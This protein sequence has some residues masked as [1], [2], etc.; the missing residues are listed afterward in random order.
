MHREMNDEV[1]DEMTLSILA[2]IG[3]GVV[4]TDLQGK[5]IYLNHAAADIVGCVA[6]QAIGRKFNDIIIIYHAVNREKMS[7]P[8]DYVL[9]HHKATGLENN[10][11]LISSDGKLKYI[12]A[13]CT[14]LISKGGIL[15]GAVVV[16]RDITKIKIYEINLQKEEQNLKKLFDD[17]PARVLVVDKNRRVVKVND[18]IIKNTGLMSE[19]IIGNGIGVSLQC[20]GSFESEL[21]CGYSKR[22]SQCKLRTAVDTLI[23]SGKDTKNTEIN[24][25]LLRQGVQENVWFN[26]NVTL[27]RGQEDQNFIVTLFDISI[28]KMKEIQARE[29]VDYCNNILNQIPVV[30]WMTDEKYI[31]SYV[32][33]PLS[34]LT[35]MNF[36]HAPLRRWFRLAHP[37]DSKEFRKAVCQALKRKTLFIKETRFLDARNEYRWFTVIG[38]PFFNQDG[39]FCGYIGSTFDIS[40]QKKVEEDLKRY[41]EMLITA[42]EAAE[43]ANMAKSEF[44]ANMSH[45]IRTPINGIVGMIDLTLQTELNEEQTDN[46]HISKACAKSLL[47]II[48]DILDFSKLEANKMTLQDIDFSLKELIEEIVRI[49]SPRAQ[50]KRLDLCYSLPTV[51]PEYVIG[52]PNRLRQILNNLI[53]NAIKFTNQGKVDILVKGKYLSET[54]VGVEFAVSDTGIGIAQKD[55]KLLFHSFS[56][57]DNT[58][59]K[60]HGG[61]GLGLA[62]SKRLVEMM[63]GRIEVISERGKGSTFSFR[64][65]FQIALEKKTEVT[66]LPILSNPIKPL[67]I[68]LVDDD[69]VNQKVAHKMLLESRHTVDT[70]VNG[71]EAVDLYDRGKY[72]AILMDIQMPIMNGLEATQKIRLMEQGIK[73][74][75]I[76]AMTAYALPG[77][78]EKFLN[79]GMDEYIPKPISIEELNKVLEKVADLTKLNTPR[80]ISV[81]KDG[82]VIFSYDESTSY[83][84]QNKQLLK[85]L[86]TKIMLLEGK[87]ESDDINS[88]ES[89]ANDIKRIADMIDAIDIKD[90]AFKI[91]LAARRGNINIVKDNLYKL[92]QDFKLFHNL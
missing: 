92:I 77:D 14:P 79:F 46:L 42:K 71:S 35:G 69:L 2:S 90:T 27:M 78:R 55:L 63:G 68:L 28:N 75:P 64:I 36:Y 38:S 20:A 8:V 43:A 84:E 85:E 80:S 44:L 34:E 37:E 23:S 5:I 57:I 15:T 67:R 29:A 13:T 18:V 87:K 45:E 11:V 31:L 22:C 24:M 26:I 7:S 91:E 59:T 41:Q 30:V 70:A 9:E 86:E 89:I 17:T 48:N 60:N 65:N 10:S 16:F 81:T 1:N 62:I 50:D 61:T 56:Q 4:S 72:D 82:E 74:T 6:D 88:I 39:H 25:T 53:S 32:N 33:R 49:H 47:N 54:E 40:R 58:Y 66:D 73:H 3:D 52:D 21:G 19:S 51:L 76:I 12:S 83:S